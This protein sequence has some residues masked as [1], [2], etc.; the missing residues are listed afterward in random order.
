MAE[1][2]GGSSEFRSSKPLVGLRRALVPRSLDGRITYN[3][4]DP[5]VVCQWCVECDP[6]A[7]RLDWLVARMGKGGRRLEGDSCPAIAEWEIG[8]VM[9]SQWSGQIQSP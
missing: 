7:K 5:V 8:P 2:R 1:L 4:V 3:R 9:E 6:G